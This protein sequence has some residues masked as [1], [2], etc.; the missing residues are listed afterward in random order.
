MTL[1]GSLNRRIVFRCFIGLIAGT[2]ALALS[3]CGDPN[4]L[5][6]ARR[7]PVKGKFV[8][9]DGKPLT[10]GKVTFV[11]MKYRQNFLTEFT[12]GTGFE[13]KGPGGDG[14]PEGDYRVVVEPL[15]GTAVKG[16]GVKATLNLPYASK[17]TDEDG[18]D[19]KATVTSDDSKN[20]FEFKLEAPN[21]AKPAAGPRG[22]R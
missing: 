10:S 1:L 5:K 9:A 11:E 22:G 13:F 18:S 21:N 7:Y 15:P 12:S 3:S 2:A 8:L 14:L 16:A 20:N 17:Y 6:G 19:L 4:P